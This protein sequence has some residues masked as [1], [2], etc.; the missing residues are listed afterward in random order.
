MRNI[1]KNAKFKD[2]FVSNDN[3][4]NI[5]LSFWISDEGKVAQLYREEWG[6]IDFYLDGRPYRGHEYVNIPN[7]FR[8]VGKKEYTITEEKVVI[9]TK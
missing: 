3:V 5:F 8:I 2:V 7:A 1:F 6:I 9:F 4:E